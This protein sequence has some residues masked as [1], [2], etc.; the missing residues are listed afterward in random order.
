MKRAALSALAV[1]VAFNVVPVFAS[2]QAGS[3]YDCLAYG[4]NC[5]KRYSLPERIAKLEAEIAKGEKVYSMAEL[6][7]LES[8]LKEDRGT[9][10]WLQRGGN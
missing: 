1:I 5:Y 3:K 6:A 4:E 8:V 2:G 10:K 7:K 9:L